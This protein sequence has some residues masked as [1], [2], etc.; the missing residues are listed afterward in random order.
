MNLKGPLIRARPNGEAA[1]EGPVEQS[2]LQADPENQPLHQNSNS[3]RNQIM[4]MVARAKANL[5]VMSP[6]ER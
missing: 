6:E 4:A 2:A 1:D 3:S 5:D